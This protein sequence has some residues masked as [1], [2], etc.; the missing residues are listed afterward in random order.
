M[1]F[2]CRSCVSPCFEQFDFLKNSIGILV[3]SEVC[4]EKYKRYFFKV[5]Y[6]ATLKHF[7]K[8]PGNFKQVESFFSLA[9]CIKLEIVTKRDSFL[10]IFGN[11]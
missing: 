9:A 8:L 6:V 11:F 3:C 10:G 7:I 1:Y 4:Y 2:Q 5:H